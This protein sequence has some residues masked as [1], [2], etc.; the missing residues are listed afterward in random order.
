MESTTERKQPKPVSVRTALKVIPVSKEAFYRK[1]KNGQLPS[2]KFGAKIL[3][4][5]DEILAAMR[6]NGN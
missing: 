4:D 6:V 5:I 1:L 2:Y 3:V